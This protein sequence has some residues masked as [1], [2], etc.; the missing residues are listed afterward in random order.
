MQRLRRTHNTLDPG[1][2][3]SLGA[4]PGGVKIENVVVT[5]E[6]AEWDARAGLRAG[7]SV[8]EQIIHDLIYT[9]GNYYAQE[10]S[11][12]EVKTVVVHPGPKA[13]KTVSLLRFVDKK[14]GEFR[15]PELRAQ[16]WNKVPSDDEQ[17]YGFQKS[18]YRW[19]CEGEEEIEAVRLL[20]NDEFP[21]QGRYQLV[22]KGSKFGRLAE[23]LSQGDVPAHDIVELLRI[24]GETPNLI[25]AL[26][27]SSNGRL[28]AE[29]V[30]LQRR[31]DQLADLRRIVEDPIS[32]ER[33][34]IHPQLKKMGWIFGGKYVGESM[35]SQLTA[36]EVLDIPLLRA[37]GS[38]HVVELKG[39]KIPE[40][41]KQH[42]GTPNPQ[43]V[44]GR[45]EDVPLIVGSEVHK[46]VGQAM[47][48]L[49]QLDEDR[50]RVLNKFKIDV[51][52]ASATVLIGHPKFEK[53][54]TKE[55]IASTFRIYNS[56][57]ARIE[58]MHYA[59]LIESAERA[60]AL[61]D[62]CS[63]LASDD[64]DLGGDQF[65]VTNS[66]RDLDPWTDADDSSGYS[67]EPPF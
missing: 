2:I 1:Q 19:H 29:A 58:I 38:L 37:D 10:R 18:D 57:H 16:T 48:Y 15:G 61:S 45:R 35:R 49:C 31:R 39:A 8:T 44:A 52:R 55:E 22:K 3:L 53:D 24:A 54:F 23:E 43:V 50:D 56:H 17:P 26:A 63:D 34:H 64:A 4:Y 51:R 27:A 41:V 67:E 28:L 14:T 65:G 9:V 66:A 20:L 62:S 21:E 60:L 46:A 30:E 13:W 42:R 47:N 33:K 40:L 12:S 25:K 7:A 11:A 6:T 59:E 5:F 32:T 36:G